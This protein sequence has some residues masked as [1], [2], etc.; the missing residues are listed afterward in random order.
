[1]YHC[2]CVFFKHFSGLSKVPFSLYKR[3]YVNGFQMYVRSNIS[4][5]ICISRCQLKFSVRII[6]LHFKWNI[7]KN[8]NHLLLLFRNKH[9][10]GILPLTQFQNLGTL[11]YFLSFLHP[12]HYSLIFSHLWYPFLLFLYHCHH[13]LAIQ[14]Y[15]DWL[16]TKPPKYSSAMPPSVSIYPLHHGQ[17]IIH[18]TNISLVS[19]MCQTLHVQ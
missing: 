15:P 6:P 9:V 4:I 2:P 19:T 16:D 14:L 5:Q 18:S 8:W 17:I 11:L 13:I 7:T 3:C 1:M 12:T 10:P